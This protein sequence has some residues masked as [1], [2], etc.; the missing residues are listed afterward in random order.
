MLRQRLCSGVRGANG[1][2]LV[3]MKR[4]QEGKPKINVSTSY[5][6]QMPTRMPEFA[7]SYEYASTYVNAQRRDGIESNFAFTDEAIV[8]LP[9]TQQ[10]FS[11][12]RYGL[13]GYVN[14]GRGFANAT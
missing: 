6:L 13:G 8:S 14:K 12:S 10:S 5:S 4:G 7:N 11:L 2:I 3:R 9:D 1:V